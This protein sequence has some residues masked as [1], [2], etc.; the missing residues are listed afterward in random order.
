MNERQYRVIRGGE[1]AVI[2]ARQLKSSPLRVTEAANRLEAT[3]HDAK[4]ADAKQLSA[5][6]LRRAPHISLNRA[7]K[8]LVRKHLDPIVA[9]G[10]EMFAGLPGIKES[11]RLPRIKD[12]PAKHLQA[13][14]R[15][16]RVAE[17]HEQ[18]F[19][20]DRNYS[21]D[22]LEQ[23]DW[24][25]QNL[26][27]A[28]RVEPGAARAQYTRATQHVKEEIARVRRA[29]DVLDSRMTEAYLDDHETLQSW[30]RASR[31]PAKLGRP[32][33]RKPMKRRGRAEAAPSP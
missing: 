20:R 17:E 15:V 10:L 26:E 7:K 28:A 16:R 3:L 22:F 32:K 1:S 13:A 25:A 14:E 2:F 4:D 12:A 11:L 27:A 33:K 24:A 23:L 21:P 8:I 30:R 31:V 19:I 5:K 9:D 18:E 29:L 6:K